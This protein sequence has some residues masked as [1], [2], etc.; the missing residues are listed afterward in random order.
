AAGGVAAGGGL[1]TAVAAKAAAAV[2]AATAVAAGGAG[3][4]AANSGDGAEGANTPPVL[5]VRPVSFT[6]TT[7]GPATRVTARVP[8]LTGLSGGLA[9]RVNALVR[10]PAERWA[11]T[12]GSDM[13]AFSQRDDPANPFTGKVDY[14]VGLGG[15]R[16][17]SVRYTFGGTV[18]TRNTPAVQMVTVDL[19]T[20]RALAGRDLLRA[21]ALTRPG[22]SALTRLLAEYGPGH[23]ALCEGPFWD[24]S[25]R[26]YTNVPPG[27]TD[28]TPGL[29]AEGV[30]YMLPTRAG[31]DFYPPVSRMG[32]SMACGRAW[33]AFHIPYRRLGRFVRPEVFRAAGAPVPSP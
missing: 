5:R 21:D 14:D 12:A 3:V 16:L 19:T 2:I 7:S 26:G 6:R 15:P 18:M 10:A 17:F 33:R 30:L 1:S 4:Y 9:G 23:G 25:G 8:Q 24:S 11:E 28:L 32:Y 31:I 13:S 27:A 29:V 20:G 22:M